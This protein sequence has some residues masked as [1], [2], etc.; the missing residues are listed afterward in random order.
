MTQNSAWKVDFVHDVG[1]FSMM[2]PRLEKGPMLID[3]T[4]QWLLYHKTRLAERHRK[5]GL[6]RRKALVAQHDHCSRVQEWIGRRGISSGNQAFDERC[7]RRKR[8]TLPPRGTFSN[9]TD[10]DK[11]VGIGLV[12]PK[13]RWFCNQNRIAPK[14]SFGATCYLQNHLIQQPQ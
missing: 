11:V 4:S 9:L 14:L 10:T 12:K 3:T 1:L 6:G 8:I 13:G 7:C 2:W 5:Y